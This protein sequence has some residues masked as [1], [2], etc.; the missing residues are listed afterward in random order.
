M[1]EAMIIKTSDD[2]SAAS[3]TE[4]DRTWLAVAAGVLGAIGAASCCV[5]PLALF[6]LGISGAWIGNLTA[7]APYQPIFVAFAAAALIY[8][9]VRVYRPPARQCDAGG[10]CASPSSN[11]VLKTALWLTTIL[12]IA[13]IA[14]PYVAVQFLES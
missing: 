2:G 8:G 4:G 13:A 11:R 6:T 14:F 10:Y 9:F 12:V 1:A 3:A 5:V 7:L